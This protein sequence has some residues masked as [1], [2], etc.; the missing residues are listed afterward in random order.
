M[1]SVWLL[2]KWHY[3][4]LFLFCCC[5]ANLPATPGKKHGRM[6]MPKKESLSPVV[7]FWSLH[8][9]FLLM[10]FRIIAFSLVLCFMRLNWLSL[11][12][13]RPSRSC[14]NQIVFICVCVFCLL[15]TLFCS[16]WLL[17]LLGKEGKPPGVAILLR[18]A[19]AGCSPSLPM[20][21]YG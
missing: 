2:G 4:L 14:T 11:A 3:L 1:F 6:E 21:L 20:S 17:G 18:G 5:F 10:L 13:L 19:R 8:L 15:F 9:F 12:L 16:V 7:L